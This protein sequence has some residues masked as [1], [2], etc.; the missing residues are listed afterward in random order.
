LQPVSS[1][2]LSIPTHTLQEFNLVGNLKRGV[3][4][5]ASIAPAAAQAQ[6]V[7]SRR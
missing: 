5:V 2:P 1:I 4:G 7:K 6:L 3:P